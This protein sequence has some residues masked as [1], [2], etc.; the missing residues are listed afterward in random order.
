[1]NDDII[2]EYNAFIDNVSKKELKDYE[3]DLTARN[4]NKNI[5]ILK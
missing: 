5:F 3:K 2:D 4:V 1:M